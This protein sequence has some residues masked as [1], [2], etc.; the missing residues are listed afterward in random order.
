M[1]TMT[2]TML[3]FAAL[4]LGSH[5]AYGQCKVPTDGIY[6]MDTDVKNVLKGAP[7]AVD[8]QLRV[9]DLCKY[10]LAVGIIHR[11]P[12]ARPGA[13]RGKAGNKGKGKQA[14]NIQRCNA[15]TA[16][17]GAAPSGAGGIA[18]EDETETYIIVSGGGT[19][20]TGGAIVNGFKSGPESEVTK[21]LNGPS[22]SGQIVGNVTKRVVGPGDIVII[23]FGVPHGWT[24]ITDHV[25]YLS[26]RP[27]PDH[28]LP[29]GY[30]NPGVKQ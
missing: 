25:D 5:A 7:P 26:V 11:G 2:K 8:Q 12:T 27:D 16:P 23:P 19:V 1:K 10:N 28:V 21:V 9:V 22:C 14:A 15:G 20:V 24:D 29:A 3:S 4:F 30:V 13:A 17:E 6:I 18:H